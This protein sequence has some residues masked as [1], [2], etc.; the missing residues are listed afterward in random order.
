MFRERGILQLP[1]VWP[2]WPQ[3]VD[4]RHG[5]DHR[6]GLLSTVISLA[7]A[8]ALVA[9]NGDDNQEDPGATLHGNRHF[10]GNVK[11]PHRSRSLTAY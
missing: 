4:S 6:K 10:D 3:G 9:S 2:T 5:C 1:T 8:G 11:Q 7:K